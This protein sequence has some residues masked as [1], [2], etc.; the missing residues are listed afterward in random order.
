MAKLKLSASVLASTLFA[1]APNF[2]FLNFLKSTIS[3]SNLGR[4]SAFQSLP[5]KVLG[6]P[7]FITVSPFLYFLLGSNASKDPSGVLVLGRCG[8]GAGSL[9]PSLSGFSPSFFP[10]AGAAVPKLFKTDSNLAKT[11]SNFAVISGLIPP[12]AI[13]CPFTLSSPINLLAAI[14]PPPSN[15]RP[16]NPRPNLPPLPR[17]LA[18]GLGLGALLEMP[19]NGRDGI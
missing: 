14:A 5:S 7:S 2:S 4:S 10:V 1:G 12:D 11:L 8:L 6:I 15:P 17:G 19:G 18:L 13:C 9:S 16:S 3:L